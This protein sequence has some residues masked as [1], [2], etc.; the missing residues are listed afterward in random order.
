[1]R[2]AASAASHAIQF[3]RHRG[4]T[5]VGPDELLLGCL[6]A[7]S[8]F[9]IAQFGPWTFDLE[10]LGVDWLKTPARTGESAKVAYSDETVVIFDRAAHIAR[11]DGSSD[12]R[13]EHLLVAFTNEETG[14][15][16]ELRRTYSV[17]NA[18]WRLAA[19][20]LPGMPAAT[21]GRIAAP[22][23]SSAA[24]EFLTPEEAA[25]ALGI[26]VQTLRAYVRSGKL[27]ALRVAGER[28]L[29]VRR[30]DLE[31]VLEPLVSEK[32]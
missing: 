4:L 12:I 8:R 7:L 14:L 1:L 29:R 20:A 11:L 19:A 22:A 5:E 3:T 25:E 28:S 10:V 23:A 24:R 16:G 13:I 26:H 21:E 15:M 32:P 9:G 31:K 6:Q 27:P 18:G 30:S 17:D 2:D